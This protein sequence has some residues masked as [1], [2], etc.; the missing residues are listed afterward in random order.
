[1]RVRVSGGGF[2]RPIRL[3]LR[4]PAQECFRA[5]GITGRRLILANCSNLPAM[6]V[7]DFGHMQVRPA[8]GPGASSSAP[9]GPAL[10]LSACRQARL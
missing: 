1:M 10:T 7:T 3:S 2:P 4:F 6:G 9:R 5:N 8:A